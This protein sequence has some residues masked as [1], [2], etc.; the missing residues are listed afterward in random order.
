ML[1]LLLKHRK[2]VLGWALFFA[3]LSLAVSFLFPR[4]YSAE[5]QVL[6]ITRSITGADPYTQ[7]RAAERLG[8]NVAQAL[9]TADFYGKVMNWPAAAFD[10]ERWQKMSER[11][12]RKNWQKD[13]RAEVVYGTGLLKLTVL[14]RGKKDAL[15]L[16][17]AVT[18]SVVSRGWEY[19]GGDVAMKMVNSPL[20]SFLPARPNYVLNTLGGFVLGFLLASLKVERG[21]R[22]GIFGSL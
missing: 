8:E 1:H 7:S 3:A 22:R 16:S 19:I 2:L 12:K 6:L 20:V 17:E 13:V 15:A 4:Y 10:K 18:Q 9:K 14:S 21:R 5:S 11:Q